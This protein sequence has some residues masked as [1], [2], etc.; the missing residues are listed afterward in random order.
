MLPH[1]LVRSLNAGSGAWCGEHSAAGQA[2]VGGP[3]PR[4]CTVSRGVGAGRKLGSSLSCHS[5]RRSGHV[6]CKAVCKRPLAWLLR[7]LKTFWVR[8]GIKKENIL[9][10]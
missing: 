10:T 4:A 2:V 3:D 7:L 5:D 1:L 6:T 9:L 8:L